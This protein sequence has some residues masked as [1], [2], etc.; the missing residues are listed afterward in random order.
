MELLLLWLLLWPTE[1]EM[2]KKVPF[3][4]IIQSNMKLRKRERKVVPLAD[5]QLL[6]PCA[7]AEM[8]VHIIDI[9]LCRRTNGGDVEQEQQQRQQ[10]QEE[11]SMDGR[12][13]AT[14]CVF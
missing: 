1:R 13:G 2:K 9:E 14:A 4:Q 11:I 3:H 5:K 8:A 12:I 6:L 7:A 10:N